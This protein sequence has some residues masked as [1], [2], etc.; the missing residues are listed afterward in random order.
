MR[1][2]YG[3]LSWAEIIGSGSYQHHMHWFGS[4]QRSLYNQFRVNHSEH[5]LVS[6]RVRLNMKAHVIK[7]TFR[8]P[9]L[10]KRKTGHINSIF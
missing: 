9:T 2:M 4:Y 7:R 10:E 3:R 5:H 1:V 8:T 6:K